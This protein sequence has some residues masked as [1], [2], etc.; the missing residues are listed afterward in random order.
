MI[1]VKIYQK[2]KDGLSMPSVM[3]EFTMDP[4]EKKTIMDVISLYDPDE[5]MVVATCGKISKKGKDWVRLSAAFDSVHY[6]YG[7]IDMTDH[8]VGKA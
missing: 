7:N 8:L 6:K 1:S 5:Y 4:S 3:K 2:S